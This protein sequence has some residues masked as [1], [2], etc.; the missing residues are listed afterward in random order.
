DLVDR[1]V[2]AD[3]RADALAALAE[4]TAG[5]FAR[6]E[7]PVAGKALGLAEVPTCDR[8]VEA[9][10]PVNVVGR[11]LDVGDLA[12]G[13]VEPPLVLVELATSSRRSWP[14]ESTSSVGIC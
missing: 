10:R 4:P 8:L 13:H 5:G 6:S 3:D 11:N 1:D 2:V 14:P 9:P 7:Q 12:L